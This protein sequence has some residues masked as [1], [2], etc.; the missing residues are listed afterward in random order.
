MIGARG[1]NYDL[2]E[3]G[4]FGKQNFIKTANRGEIQPYTSE[5]K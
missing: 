1:E 2:W 4:D 5:N 3:K